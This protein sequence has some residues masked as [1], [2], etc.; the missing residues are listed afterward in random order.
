M[1]E[2]KR[3]DV[4]NI[5]KNL[6][7]NL[8]KK[9]ENFEWQKLLLGWWDFQQVLLECPRIWF[10]PCVG[11]KNKILDC[12]TS[13]EYLLGV[14]LVVRS[15]VTGLWCDHDASSKLIV[16]LRRQGCG[17]ALVGKDFG[18]LPCGLLLE[19]FYLDILWKTLICYFFILIKV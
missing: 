3:R 5:K 7:K 1:V 2:T 10:I 6:K 11:D 8:R 4:V 17:S 12:M 15:K 9:S 14:I 19:D 13:E 18:Q 16:F